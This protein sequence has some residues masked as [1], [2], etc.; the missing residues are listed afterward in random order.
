MD[1]TN[2]VLYDIKLK[3]KGLKKIR[4]TLIN[5][6]GELLDNRTVMSEKDFSREI[7]KN[8]V[9]EV[10]YAHLKKEDGVVS[11]NKVL[12]PSLAIYISEILNGNDEYIKALMYLETRKHTGEE[13]V[14]QIFKN[15]EFKMFNKVEYQKYRSTNIFKEKMADTLTGRIYVKK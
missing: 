11:F 7:K 9:P 5:K 4:R 1:L 6:Y 14:D 3:K 13:Y 10:T 12:N 15:I 2:I 8:E